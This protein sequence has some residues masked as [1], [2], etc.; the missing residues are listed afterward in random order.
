MLAGGNGF[1]N[2]YFAQTIFCANYI[3]VFS[4]HVTRIGRKLML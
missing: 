1:E 3:L 2:F 4:A